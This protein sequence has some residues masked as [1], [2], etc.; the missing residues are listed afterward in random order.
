MKLI[1]KD[2]TRP[3]DRFVING[4][5]DGEPLVNEGESFEVDDAVGRD[6]LAGYFPRLQPVSG[7]AESSRTLSAADILARSEQIV[8]KD[9]VFV[10]DEPE[11][12]AERPA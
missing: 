7:Q 1:F 11:Q 3:Q 10:E 8:V 2:P 12:E 5:L 6:L 4:R 9:N